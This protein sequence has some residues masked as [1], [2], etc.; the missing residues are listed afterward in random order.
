MIWLGIAIGASVVVYL[1][2]NGRRNSDPMNRKAAAEICDYLV[3]PGS[4][5]D[6]SEIAQILMDNA[7]YRSHARHIA[8][9]VPVLLNKAGIPWEIAKSSQATILVAAELVPE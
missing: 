6:P 9:M 5:S 4:Q 7:R 2:F 1:I 8:S 3:S